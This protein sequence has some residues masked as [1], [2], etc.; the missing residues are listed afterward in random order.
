M[1]VRKLTVPLVDVLVPCFA[2]S[3]SPELAIRLAELLAAV[4]TRTAVP[5]P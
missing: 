2:R 3:I 1:E 4:V 5:K